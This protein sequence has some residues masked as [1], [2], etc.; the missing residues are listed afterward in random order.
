MPVLKIGQMDRAPFVERAGD[1]SPHRVQR[2]QARDSAAVAPPV[3]M[4]CIEVFTQ[5]CSDFTRPAAEIADDSAASS[6]D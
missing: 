3:V 5:E 6:A 1:E 2:H 4:R